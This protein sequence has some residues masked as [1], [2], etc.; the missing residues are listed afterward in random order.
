MASSGTKNSQDI[1]FLLDRKIQKWSVTKCISESKTDVYRLG[2]RLAIARTGSFC[3]PIRLLERYLGAANI[4]D[5]D[6]DEY[7]FRAKSM[8]VLRSYR[9]LDLIAI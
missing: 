4:T 5:S 9:N 8:R 3:C 2:N 1:P 7:I 6:S